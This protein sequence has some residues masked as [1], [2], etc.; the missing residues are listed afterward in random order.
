VRFPVELQLKRVVKYYRSFSKFDSKTRGWVHSGTES[1][2][3]GHV[4]TLSC[5]NSDS[6]V[7]NI[8]WD[9][10]PYLTEGNFCLPFTREFLYNFFVSAE[11]VY[12]FS[13]CCLYVCSSLQKHMSTLQLYHI[14]ETGIFFFRHQ[15]STQRAQVILRPEHEADQSSQSNAELAFSGSLPPLPPTPALSAFNHSGIFTFYTSD[16]NDL[17]IHNTGSLPSDAVGLPWPWWQL[18]G[19]N[20]S[21]V[22]VTRPA[23]ETVPVPSVAD[24]NI[25]RWFGRSVKTL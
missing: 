18:D 6:Y 22:S 16:H 14:T 4:W 23:R 20:S 19:S 24:G 11:L 21:D 15:V 10:S 5:Q 9:R 17:R 8:I 12:H 3:P 1:W 7:M 13:L 2:A 25:V